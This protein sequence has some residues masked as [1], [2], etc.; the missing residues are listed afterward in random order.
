M[1]RKQRIELLKLPQ[2]PQVCAVFQ[3][4]P[5]PSRNLHE[6]WMSVENTTPI[7]LGSFA[8]LGKDT[9]SVLMSSLGLIY[10]FFF[11]FPFFLDGGSASRG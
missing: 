10:F 9:V 6:F 3:F 7:S 1:R 8:E 4:F 2:T 11:C 5:K